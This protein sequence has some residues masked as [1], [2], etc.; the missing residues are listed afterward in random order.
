MST[1]IF[2][3]GFKI[4]GDL[5]RGKLRFRCEMRTKTQKIERMRNGQVMIQVPDDGNDDDG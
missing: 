1:S 4:K 2:E 3:S 5:H